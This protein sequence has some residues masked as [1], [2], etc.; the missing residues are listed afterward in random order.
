MEQLGDRRGFACPKEPP[1]VG[2][3]S[4]IRLSPKFLTL[5]SLITPTRPHATLISHWSR[6]TPTQRLSFVGH[7]LHPHDACSSLTTPD[8]H[9]M[10]VSGIV[11]L[12]LP[13]GRYICQQHPLGS[14]LVKE[15]YYNRKRKKSVRS[16]SSYS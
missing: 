16:D 1:E 8:I 11:L 13:T 4:R 3:A 14:S 15:I 12:I 2:T 6:P 9:A 5:Y 7:G 10:L